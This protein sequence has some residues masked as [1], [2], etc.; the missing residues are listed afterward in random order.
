MG[1]S[2]FFVVNRIGRGGGLAVMWKG[3][4]DCKI[5]GSSQNHIDVIMLKNGA[6]DWRLTCFYGFPE[7]NR[8]RKSWDFI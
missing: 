3:N 5:E 1:F 8:R 2:N 4:I 6:P 7:R